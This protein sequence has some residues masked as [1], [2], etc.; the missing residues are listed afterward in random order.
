MRTNRLTKILGDD[1]G[2]EAISAEDRRWIT[3]YW[4]PR[5]IAAGLRCVA[6]K[7]PSSY[8]GRLSV[9]NIH[10]AMPTGIR[11]RSFDE[12]DAA[13]DWLQAQP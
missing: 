6:S 3:D 2:L 9:E 1:S 13:R 8:F 7:T 11:V 4:L 10:S 5:A 12:I